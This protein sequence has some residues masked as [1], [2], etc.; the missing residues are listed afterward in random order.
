MFLIPPAPP[1]QADSFGGLL[2]FLL[3]IGIS[4]LSN[5]LKQKQQQNGEGGPQPGEEGE[6]QSPRKSF[7]WEEE[8]R[9]L[10]EGERPGREASPPPTPPP[11][12]RPVLDEPDAS[13]PPPPPAVA[14][15]RIPS[16]P[17]RPKPVRTGSGRKP[18][19]AVA[20]SFRKEMAERRAAMHQRVGRL[21]VN[22]KKR[23]EEMESAVAER[24]AGLP[25]GGEAPRGPMA[26]RS[27][28]DRRR[29]ASPAVRNV[30]A[31]LNRPSSASEAIIAAEILGQPKG[32]QP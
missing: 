31:A 21:K 27:A 1:I 7:D 32:L 8:L 10:I 15:A 18:A 20:D 23:A 14:E 16:V 30:L 11:V 26:L 9:R 22:W 29:Q 13:A 2:F 24:T 3:I 4:A 5:W 25:Q 28:Q 6:G 12:I 19:T 17:G